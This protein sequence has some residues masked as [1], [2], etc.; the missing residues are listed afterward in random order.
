MTRIKRVLLWA[1][2]IAIILLTAFS[3]YG[4]FMGAERARAFF[5]TLGLTLYW[6]ALAA[7]LVVGI[8][9]FRRLLRVPALLL[10]HV[11][12]ILVVAGSLWGSKAGHTVGK[13]LFGIDKILEGRMAVLERSEDSRV[14]LA[15]GNDIAE[16]PFSVRLKDFRIEYYR[17]G[18]LMI[19]SRDGGNWRLPA[20]PGRELSLGDDLGRVT[21]QRIFENFKIGMEGE[22]RVPYD[23]PGGSNPALEVTIEKPDG[24]ETTRYVFERF[25]GH[26]HPEDRIALR[27]RRTISDYI[28]ELQVLQEGKVLAAKDIEVNHPLRYG[29]YHFYQSSYGQD[30]GRDYTVLMVVSDSGLNLVYAGYALLI[31]GVFWHF[32]GRRALKAWRDRQKRQLE[33]LAEPPGLEPAPDDREPHGD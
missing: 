30:R 6:F 9:V 14:R 24:T 19:Q 26:S 3:I 32:W 1:A 18:Q 28:S 15:D 2:L 5:N 25:P 22:D 31:A 8:V 21:V 4:A 23:A 17:P 27:Y 20:E 13:R 29:G 33:S 10:M 12:C 16:L 11:G 7:L